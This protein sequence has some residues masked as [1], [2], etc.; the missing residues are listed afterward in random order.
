MQEE[1]LERMSTSLRRLYTVQKHDESPEEFADIATA[2]GLLRKSSNL[3]TV[4]DEI[5]EQVAKKVTL[6][7]RNMNMP[8]SGILSVLMTIFLM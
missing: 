2:F 8:T 7:Y 6:L 4:Q 3:S 5:Y 1:I